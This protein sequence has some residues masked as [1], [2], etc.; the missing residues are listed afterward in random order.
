V[1]RASRA[2]AGEPRRPG[3][4]L[5]GGGQPPALAGGGSH[6]VVAT[7]VPADG[8]W[9]SVAAVRQ[10]IGAWAYTLGAAESRPGPEAV[11]AAVAVAC[12]IREIAL[13]PDRRRWNVGGEPTRETAVP[14]DVG[15]LASRSG[16]PAREV[17]RAL[18]LLTASRVVT[19]QIGA[20]AAT[21][22]LAGGMLAP[23]PAVA[24]IAWGAVRERVR[25]AGGSLPSTQAVV[26]ELA[27]MLGTFDAG[28]AAPTV[29][30]S[31]RDLED[32]TGFGRSTVSEALVTLER[33][34]LVGVETR[35]GRTTRFTLRPE[36]FGLPGDSPRAAGVGDDRSPGG[37]PARSDRRPTPGSAL[38]TDAPATIARSAAFPPVPE[39]RTSHRMADQGAAGAPVRLGEFGGTPI[40]GP[41]GTPIVVE[42]DAEGRWTCRVGPF[43]TLGP[44]GPGE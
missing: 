29:R 17:E 23:T 22:T 40:Y 44:V 6:E 39:S 5:H 36:A 19:R 16:Y 25:A 27:A 20:T 31:V 18:A 8:H 10:A 15:E 34:D 33:V 42:C 9:V 12:A 32:A 26:R 13:D 41:A 24:R 7:T 35:A 4:S 37:A 14:E 38:Q 28:G 11:R 43:L 3:P 21:V 1:S 2:P 30:A